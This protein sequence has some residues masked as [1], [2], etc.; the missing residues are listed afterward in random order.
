MPSVDK[1]YIASGTVAA[2]K[3]VVD[4]YLPVTFTVNKTWKNDTPAQRGEYL[5]VQLLCDGV[6][7][8]EE[9]GGVQRLTEDNNWSY[10]WTN[11]PGGHT[12]TVVEPNVPEDYVKDEGK[13]V[14]EKEYDDDGNAVC[15]LVTEEITNTYAANPITFD[16]TGKLLIVAGAM[17]LMVLY[18]K[19][20][21][22]RTPTK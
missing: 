22:K 16:N 20:R 2:S 14:S 11:L 7:V 1:I 12:Y 19:R 5:E 6:E 15:I 13:P 10:T 9:E 21:I 17:I 4:Q 3:T 8:P 18:L